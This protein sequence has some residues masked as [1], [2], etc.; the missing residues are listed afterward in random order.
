MFNPAQAMKAMG[1][2]K[3]FGKNH[4][5]V[6]A[7]LQKMHEDGIPEGTVLELRITRPGGEEQVTNMKVLPSDVELIRHLSELKK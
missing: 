5:K 2:V 7:F 4:P 1:L 6:S 3:E